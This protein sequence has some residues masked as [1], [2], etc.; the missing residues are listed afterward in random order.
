MNNISAGVL[1]GF[2]ATIAL[3]VLSRVF[4]P[5]YWNNGTHYD[6]SASSDLCCRAGMELGAFASD[7]Q[8]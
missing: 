3:S 2:I 7:E 4:R 1:A 8:S 5:E 6:I